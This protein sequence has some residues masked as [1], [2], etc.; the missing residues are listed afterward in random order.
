MADAQ[1]AARA[2]AGPSRVFL[3]LYA[4]FAIGAGARSAVQLITR[5]SHAPLAYALSALAAVIYTVGLVLLARWGHGQARRAMVALCGVELAGVLGVGLLSVLRTDLF[6]DAT[7][8]SSFGRGYLY[9]P[10]LL[11]VVVLLWLRR[12]GRSASV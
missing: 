7:V 4:T 6:P 8:W 3:I 1:A 2:P 10:A 5:A 9:I 11:P 12:N